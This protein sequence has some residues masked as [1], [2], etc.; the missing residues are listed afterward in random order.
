LSAS[1]PYVSPICHDSKGISDFYFADG[2]YFDNSG[3]VSAL[4]L[5]LKLL[6][7]KPGLISRVMIL[8]INP[9]SLDHA[10][11]APTAKKP[12]Q[13]IKSR[14]FFM[15]TLGPLLALFKVRDPILN[16]RNQ[17]EV[18]LLKSLEQARKI[19]H[20][21]NVILKHF[22]IYFPSNPAAQR[23]DSQLSRLSMFFSDKGEYQPPLS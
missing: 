23:A 15:T 19:C 8:Q 18:D 21:N 3:F 9:F 22:P 7:S 1:F 10:E 13:P 17:T 14:G 16:S 4:E 12:K 5:L 11:Q 20:Q 6:D 2:G